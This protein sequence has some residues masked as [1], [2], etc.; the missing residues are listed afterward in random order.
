MTPPEKSYSRE[1][2]D[3]WEV[4][5]FDAG[6]LVD[7]GGVPYTLAAARSVLANGIA[8]S[9]FR[10]K[11]KIGDPFRERLVALQAELIQLHK[12]WPR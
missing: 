12:D 10:D 11:R 6:R 8:R 4:R 2:L 5:Q 3:S 9:A 1:S 7:D